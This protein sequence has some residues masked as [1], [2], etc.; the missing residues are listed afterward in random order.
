MRGPPGY[1]EHLG[2]Y[3]VWQAGQQEEHLSWAPTKCSESAEGLQMGSC[4]EASTQIHLW[5]DVSLM[6]ADRQ[7]RFLS[8]V[9][10]PALISSLASVPL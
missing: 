8:Q 9:S 2:T 4:M 5:V 7:A 6:G 1:G 3:G 10:S